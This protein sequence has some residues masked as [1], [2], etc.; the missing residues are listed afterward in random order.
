MIVRMDL[1]MDMDLAESLIT[2]EWEMVMG[3]GF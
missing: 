2:Q 3:K 1:E